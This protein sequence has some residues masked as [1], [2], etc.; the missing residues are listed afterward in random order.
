VKTGLIAPSAASGLP[1][2]P[3]ASEEE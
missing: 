1:L 3:G 2:L